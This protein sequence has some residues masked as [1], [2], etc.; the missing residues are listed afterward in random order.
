MYTYRNGAW[1]RLDNINAVQY[2]QDENGRTA[3]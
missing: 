1:L 2:M 3:C